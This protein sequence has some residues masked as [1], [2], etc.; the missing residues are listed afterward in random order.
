MLYLLHKERK[1]S[2][3]MSKVS[4]TALRTE[5]RNVYVEKIAAFFANDE[6]VLRV[7]SNKIAFPIVDREGNEDFIEITVK[8]PTGANKRTEPY[9]G[10]SLAEEYRMNLDAKA[11]KAK[12]NAKAK[13]E[14]IARDEKYRQAKAEQKKSGD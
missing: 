8:I 3:T 13:A 7:A 9:D 1:E 10:Y 12:A 5:V 4:R 6:E 14:K 11:E 2:I